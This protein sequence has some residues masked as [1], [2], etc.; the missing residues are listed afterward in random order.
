MI[1]RNIDGTFAKGRVESNDDKLKRVKAFTEAWV[2]RSDYILD[3]KHPK[4][5]NCWRSFM[6]TIKGKN[7]GCSDEW[8]DYRTFYND[9]WPNYIEGYT[10]QRFN[11][12]SP[13]SK[14]NFFWGDRQVVNNF[15]ENNVLLNYNGIE[16]TFKE[17]SIHY[18]ISLNGIRNRYYKNVGL[19]SDEVLF[20]KKKRIKK[21]LLNAKEL[22]FQKL[23]DKASK[24]C[25]SYKKKD[26]TKRFSFDLTSEWMINNI[27]FK[28]CTYCGDTDHVGC[29]RIDN[30]KGHTK[31][32]VIPCCKDC[33]TVR[34][35]MFSVEEMMEIGKTIAQ[36]KQKRVLKTDE[37][38]ITIT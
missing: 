7:I 3:I 10:L 30:S 16:K 22:V 6:F 33:N 4:I 11:K 19:P 37:V 5:Y 36:I 9:V 13:F 27:L 8:K 15:R 26:L 34:G 1:E 23:K 38:F 17:W 12:R 21:D 28:P 25:S 29:D 32:N 14:D 24:M 35:D 31:D 2:N 20:G 18:S